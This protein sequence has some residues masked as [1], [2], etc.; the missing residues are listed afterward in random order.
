MCHR[1]HFGHAQEAERSRMRFIAHASLSGVASVIAADLDRFT[2][3]NWADSKLTHSISKSSVYFGGFAWAA[4]LYCRR[5][6]FAY[7]ID[8]KTKLKAGFVR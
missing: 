4:R 5:F 7:V 3:E 8:L 2:A 1:G 6:T